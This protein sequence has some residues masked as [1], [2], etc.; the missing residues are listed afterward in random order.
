MGK[1]AAMLTVS[2]VM[3]APPVSARADTEDS[4][5]GANYSVFLQAL[6]GDGIEIDSRRAISE[7]H[8][9]CELIRPP[10]DGSLWDAGQKVRSMHPDWSVGTALHFANRSVQHICPSR[11]SF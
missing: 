3:I 11:G 4:Y 8:A 2:M 6:A 9:V 5:P 10:G 1:L 7:G